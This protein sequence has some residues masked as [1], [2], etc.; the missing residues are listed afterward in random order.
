MNNFKFYVF[1][2]FKLGISATVCHAELAQV[3]KDEAPGKSTVFRWYTEFRGAGGADESECRDCDVD[4]AP[5]A[6]AGRPRT[7]R[8]P[9]MI[10]AVQDLLSI[11]CRL[12]VRELADDLEIGKSVVH[13]ILTEDLGL[14]NVASVWVPHVLSDQNRQSRVNCAKHLLHLF[15]REGMECL[16]NRFA[17]EDETWVYLTGQPR[18][19]QNR[20][21]LQ[22]TQP[23]PQVVRRT[24]AD[25]KVMLLVAFTPSKRFSITAVPSSERIDANRIVE[26]VRHTGDLWRCLRSNPIK[27]SEVL[28]HWDNARPHSA[29]VVKDFMESRGISM[30]FQS[31][32]SPDFNLCDR[33]LFNWLKADLCKQDFRDHLELQKA[34]LQWAR[35]LDEDHLQR[36]V[37]KLMDHCKAVIDAQGAYVTD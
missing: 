6:S 21:W 12:S 1:T 17:V 19:Q 24:L 23:R 27:L 29:R 9:A 13:E 33:F 15:H 16:C 7:T 14:R 25:K 26:F 32:Y 20:A 5:G 2:R 22:R 31:P 4:E 36:E 34:A 3:H 37:Q 30:V 35:Q 8:T 10:E 18:K 28:W 11:D